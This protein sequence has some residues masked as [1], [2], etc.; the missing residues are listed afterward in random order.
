[1]DAWGI[2]E[3]SRSSLPETSP[4]CTVSAKSQHLISSILRCL[5]H[6]PHHLT[7]SAHHAST[8]K[9]P[10]SLT[11]LHPCPLICS[12]SFVVVST[13]SDTL[14]PYPLCCGSLILT[15]CQSG[16]KSTS[17]LDIEENVLCSVLRWR[18]AK[19]SPKNSTR[20]QRNGV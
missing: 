9:A 17:A 7:N 2:Q 13:A 20:T 15:Y 4:T 18:N 11:V 12:H 3:A 1:M 19:R 14:T 16:S 5:F 6:D 10:V 8:I